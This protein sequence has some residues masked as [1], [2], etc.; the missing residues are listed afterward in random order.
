[1][2]GTQHLGPAED[3]AVRPT[4]AGVPVALQ[5]EGTGQPYVPQLLT[6]DLTVPANNSMMV[7]C[8]YEVAAN[9][10]LE[11]AAGANFAIE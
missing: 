3:F 11:L 7:A 2:A 8:D 4:V 1:M 10:T 6:S 5:G 9:V